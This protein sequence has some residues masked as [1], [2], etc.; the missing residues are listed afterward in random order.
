MVLMVHANTTRV[1]ENIIRSIP[2]PEWTN[3]WHPVG[4][5][6]LLD[7]LE[8]GV[9][10]NNLRV[11]SREY[12]MN[13]SGSRIFGV[14][15]LDDAVIDGMTIPMGFRHAI[16]KSM[17]IGICAGIK[18]FVCDNLAL[19]GDLV[20]FRKH[21]SGLTEE[22]L[23]TLAV[24]AVTEVI[25]RMEKYRNWIDNLK[26]IPMIEGSARNPFALR[27]YPDVIEENNF[28]IVHTD[29]FK[30]R[31]F[32]MVFEHKIFAITSIP[33]FMDAFKDEANNALIQGYPINC[34][35]TLFNAVTRMAKEEPIFKVSQVTGKME[36][37]IKNKI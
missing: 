34:W 31:V 18:I 7:S 12:S 37:M 8:R 14:W 20:K 4:H 13:E 15:G 23:S 25:G 17:P 21:T 16:D 19:S 11:T 3:T 36:A 22:S 10:E 33:K 6:R 29:G 2:E 24:E 9:N 1:G 32:D 5:A 28:G 35:Y 26:D 30:S 27:D